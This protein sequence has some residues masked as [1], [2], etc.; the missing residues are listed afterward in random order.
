[1]GDRGQPEAVL[2]HY[3]PEGATVGGNASEGGGTSG[4]GVASG[5]DASDIEAVQLPCKAVAQHGGTTSPGYPGRPAAPIQR[6]VL[7][8]E[9]TSR[10]RG[11]YW[12]QVSKMWRVNVHHCF[13]EHHI[14]FFHDEEEAARAWDK[15]ALRIK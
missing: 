10:F 3:L 8:I 7:P 6:Q 14:G 15:E 2:V 1:M 4:P 9:G 11:V 5:V 13:R 12:N